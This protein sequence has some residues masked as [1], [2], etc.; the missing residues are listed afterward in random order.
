MKSGPDST[1]SL[2]VLDSLSF[3]HSFSLV[4]L[5]TKKIALSPA[6]FGHL[7]LV[8]LTLLL[9][10]KVTLT[11]VSSQQ[12]SF[13]NNKQANIFFHPST[14][15]AAFFLYHSTLS[16][17]RRLLSVSLSSCSLLV[18]CSLALFSQLECH[19]LLLML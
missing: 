13:E 2:I 10:P 15:R 3:F 9:L 16:L 4:L 1:A 14:K 5:V 18:F 6:H 7:L 12:T 17:Q 11:F 8:S 19:L